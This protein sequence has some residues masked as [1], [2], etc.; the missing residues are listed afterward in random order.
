MHFA[1]YDGFAPNTC[2]KKSKGTCFRSLSV[3]S[4]RTST[5]Q[6]T[7]TRLTALSGLTGTGDDERSDDC[8][9]T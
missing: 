4:S 3:I 6:T 1:F 2:L 5:L 9:G 7:P 8:Y